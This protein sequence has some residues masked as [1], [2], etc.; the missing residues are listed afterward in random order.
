MGKKFSIKRDPT[1]KTTVNLPSPGQDAVPVEFTFTLKDRKF[2]TSFDEDRFN[3]FNIELKDYAEKEEVKAADVAQKIIDYEFGQ[4]KSIVAGWDIEE[5]YNDDNLRAFVEADSQWP[6][7]II[8][9]Y[10]SAYNKARE[11]N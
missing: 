11:G 6:A 1:F 3:F 8:G 9:G 10:L 2:L 4:L 7:A 5:E